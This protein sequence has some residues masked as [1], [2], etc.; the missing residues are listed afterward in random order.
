MFSSCTS[1]KTVKLPATV[2]E[3]ENE[4]FYHSGIERIVI[5]EGV[6]RIGQ[7]AFSHCEHLTDIVIPAT[8]TEICDNAFTECPKF[9]LHAEEGSYAERYARQNHNLMQYVVL[10]PEML[11]SFDEPE[12]A[13][14]RQDTPPVPQR[15]RRPQTG[16]AAPGFLF[17]QEPAAP[18]APAEPPEPRKPAEQPNMIFL[19]PTAS[20]DAEKEPAP[21]PAPAPE[22]PPQ[23]KKRP[24]A[25]KP[26]QSKPEPQPAAEPVP[27]AEEPAP[28]KP[29]VFDEEDELTYA[30]RIRRELEEARKK[31]VPVDPK[32]K[33]PVIPEEPEKPKKTKAPRKKKEGS[34]EDLEIQRRAKE[35]PEET[36]ARRRASLL[37]DLPDLPEDR[38]RKA[39][40][41]ESPAEAKARRRTSLLSD[42]PDLPDEAPHP[43]LPKP[44]APPPTHEEEDSHSEQDDDPFADIHW[45]SDQTTFTIRL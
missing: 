15:I 36:K 25:T 5:P 21:A 2:T 23:P 44:A 43:A 30:E 7:A 10:N 11:Q 29:A 40:A 13:A 39:R 12:E 42:L 19:P 34:E 1:L 38:E 32:A 14:P 9:R 28:K 16:P 18:A 37:D 45:N 35:T 20:E 8:V 24:A 27:Q 33:L 31:S 6:T 41:M 22:Q 4:A 17:R 3:I 26:K